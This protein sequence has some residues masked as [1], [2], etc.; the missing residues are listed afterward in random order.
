VTPRQVVVAVLFAAGVVVGWWSARRR[1]AGTVR[2]LERAGAHPCPPIDVPDAPPVPTVE[3]PGPWAEAAESEEPPRAGWTVPFTCDHCDAENA[4]LAE[5]DS[6][7]VELIR[8]AG[9]RDPRFRWVL[10]LWC[11][12]CP[13]PS[14]RPIS[15]RSS[16]LWR[17]AFGLEPHDMY[18]PTV[19]DKVAAALLEVDDQ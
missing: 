16:E 5:P 18:A 2:L 1:L 14:M 10:R 11:D 8:W 13:E 15:E 17:Y 19:S 3:P 4:P 6:Q 12:N 7:H 9:E